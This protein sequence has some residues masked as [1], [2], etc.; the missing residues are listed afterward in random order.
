MDSNGSGTL[1]Y[2][3]LRDGFYALGV[4]VKDDVSHFWSCMTCAGA[5]AATA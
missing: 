3:E 1:S 2:E 5:D 4:C